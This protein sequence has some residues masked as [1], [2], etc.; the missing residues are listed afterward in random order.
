MNDNA[1]K[2]KND[3]KFWVKI[4][5][6]LIVVTVFVSAITKMT[7]LPVD[8]DN[9]WVGYYGSIIGG[10][11]TLAG[12]VI[13][14]NYNRE[15]RK[16]D[17]RHSIIPI[18]DVKVRGTGVADH[19]DAAIIYNGEHAVKEM[20]SINMINVGMKSAKELKFSINVDEIN[21]GDVGVR[22]LVRVDEEYSIN[23]GVQVVD[24][25]SLEENPKSVHE[26][27]L[28]W[29][30]K[31]LIGNKYKQISHIKLNVIFKENQ[32]QYFPKVDQIGEAEYVN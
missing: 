1:N 7:L 8:T 20:F 19:G 16:E 22:E 12:V 25:N 13:T 27:D 31:D 30:Y 4:V 26:I 3:R 28:I 14:I 21:Y 2:R 15:V 6:L 18:F 32:K 23:L 11:L 9:V 29:E 24:L 10:I 5:L 17:F